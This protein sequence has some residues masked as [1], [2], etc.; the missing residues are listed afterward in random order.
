M[1]VMRNRRKHE[2]KPRMDQQIG[3]G[4]TRQ[5]TEAK[6]DTGGYNQGSKPEQNQ[7][8]KQMPFLNMCTSPYSCPCEMS[9]FSKFCSSS[10]VH[11]WT[12]TAEISA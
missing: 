10:Q 5:Y 8:Q 9:S 3:R 1:D 7:A 11:I 6:K 4:K 12:N 2:A